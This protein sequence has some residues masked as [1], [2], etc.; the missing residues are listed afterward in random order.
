MFEHI[1]YITYIHTY[2]HTYEGS[3]LFNHAFNTFS[4]RLYRVGHIQNHSDSERGYPLLYLSSIH[5]KQGMELIIK[6]W[7]IV[8][9]CSQNWQSPDYG[10]GEVS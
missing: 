3:V 1:I 2:I 9:V 10:S 8:K 7:F 4:L 5:K 6:V